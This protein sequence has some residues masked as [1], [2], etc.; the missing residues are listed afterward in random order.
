MGLSRCLRAPL[1][2]S[3]ASGVF[4]GVAYFAAQFCKHQVVSYGEKSA[5]FIRLK[6]HLRFEGS[7]VSAR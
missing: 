1:P 7:P 3:F 2:H 6:R 4:K 5:E